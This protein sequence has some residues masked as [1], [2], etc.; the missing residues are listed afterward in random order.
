[1][2][3]IALVLMLDI[4]SVSENVMLVFFLGEMSCYDCNIIFDIFETFFFPSKFKNYE[5]EKSRSTIYS[6][7]FW[8]FYREEVEQ[9]K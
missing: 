6:E 7:S 1:M 3:R 5:N 9:H 4:L 8:S 2:S